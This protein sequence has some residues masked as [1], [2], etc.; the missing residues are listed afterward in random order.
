MCGAMKPVSLLFF[1][2]PRIMCKFGVTSEQRC[3]RDVKQESCFSP[4]SKDTV[5]VLI[6]RDNSYEYK[7]IGY[8]NVNG[9]FFIATRLCR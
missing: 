3:F 4:I 7:S 9:I 5:K 8:S 1:I 6:R 2:Y